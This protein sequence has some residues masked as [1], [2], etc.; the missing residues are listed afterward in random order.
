MQRKGRSSVWEIEHQCPQCGAP[1]TLEETDRLF[2]CSYCRTRLYLIPKGYFRYYLP[3][4]ELFSKDL[5]FIPH[6]RLKGIIFF[7]KAFEVNHRIIDVSPL[8]IPHPFLPPSL[9]VRPQVL[10]LRLILPEMKANFFN[11]SIPI[12]TMIQNILMRSRPLKGSASS[13]SLVYK[14][15]IGETVSLIYSPIFIDKGMAYDAI[16]G[17]PL[18][19]ISKDFTGGLL[20]FDQQKDFQIKFISTLCPH[21]GWDLFGDKN[22]M[23]L[24]CKNCNSAWGASQAGLEQLDFGMIPSKEEKAI[25]LPFWRMDVRIQGLEIQSNAE[26]MKIGNEPKVM[27]RDIEGSDLYFWSPA[28][29]IPPK[30]F[31]RLIHGMTF[32]QPQEKFEKSLPWPSLYPVS[33]PVSEAVESIKVTMAYSVMDKEKHFSNLDEMP[34]HLNESLL[35]FVPFISQGIDLIQPHTQ[36]CIPKNLLKLGRD[37]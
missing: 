11:P 1:V 29:K 23:V 31:L 6:W 25:Y 19:P 10:K 32:S 33:L 30:L 9:G 37:L 18:A 14:A 16:L 15:F 27:G 21:C 5:I 8:A 35:V 34:I 7:C 28:F 26:L 36:L 3:P 22:S 20:S 2:S 12:E 17:K 24:F 13:G 4:S